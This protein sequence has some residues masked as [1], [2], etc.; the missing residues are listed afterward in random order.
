M[1]SSFRAAVFASASL[2]VLACA[3][4]AA[5]QEASQPAQADDG[6]VGDIVVTAR[7]RD[8]NLQTTPVSATVLSGDNLL[9]QNIRSFQDIRGAASN[10]ELVPT[11]SGGTSFTVRGIGQ[12]NDQVNN[13]AKTG[14]YINEMY[15]ARQEGN[16][17]S[18]FDVESIQVLKGPQGTL[19]GKNTTAGAVLLTTVKPTDQTEGYFQ[20]RAGSYKRIDTEGAINAPLADNLFGRL[21]FRTQNVDG[22]TKHLLGDGRSN[23]IDNKS[24]RG[25][26]RYEGTRLTVDLLG[27]YNQSNTDGGADIMLGC[28]P[29]ASYIQN[30]DALHQVPYCTRYAPLGKDNLVYGGAS[31]SLPT[32]SAVTDVAVGGDA[33]STTNRQVGKPAFNDTSVFTLNNR[34]TYAVTDD[35]DLRSITTYRRS[36]ARYYSPVNQAPDDIYAEYDDTITNQFTQEF[37][38]G[39]SSLDKRLNWVAGLYYSDQKTS[40]LQDTGPDWIDPLGYIYDGKVRYKS[41]AAFAQASFKITPRLE[42]TAGL[43]YS[44][45]RKSGSSY[46]FYAG[47]GASYVD[48][49]G[50]TQQ[51]GWFVGD[52]LGGLKN[53]AGAPFTASDS[54]SWSSVDP[55]FQIGYEWSDAIYTYATA[56]HGYNAGGFNQQLGGQPAD[57]RFLS[58]YNPEKLWSYEAGI[59]TNLFDRRATINLAGFYQKY[60]DIQ[61][62][63]IVNIGGI[64]TNQ[65]QTAA[66]ASQKGFEA[67]VVLRPVRDLQIRGN[68][69]YIDQKYDSIRPGALITL[70]TPLGTT[71]DYTFSAAISYTYHVGNSGTLTPSMDV[72]GMGKRPACQLSDPVRYECDLPAYALVGFRLDYVPSDDSLWTLGLYGTNIFDKTVYLGR[73]GFAYGQG[74]DHYTPGRPAEFGVEAR[75]R[76]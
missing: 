50:V 25:Q 19:F 31:L 61:S 3:L 52:F 34:M 23:N 70:D 41:Y 51:C 2:S 15:V 72:R 69:A 32:S 57:G 9:Q 28:D 8:E 30:Y 71:P 47:N 37:T 7:R 63:V 64:P 24:V 48:N 59:K 68:F 11:P 46:V 5:A 29:T 54:G 74:I 42:V 16:D 10:L 1:K 67:E 55:K 65:L 26:L 39:G 49:A 36:R 43:R 13:D 17:L 44:H 73:T 35:I 21:S 14:L 27:E 12:V 75:V 76:F 60:S 38:L 66:S 4:P 56:A 18:F 20:V 45:D 22:F 33:N 53:C 58:S 6:A 40:L 62:Q